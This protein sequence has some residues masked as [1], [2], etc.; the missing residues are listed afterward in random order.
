MSTSSFQG[1]YQSPININKELAEYDSSLKPLEINYDPKSAIKI[2][3]VGHCFNVEFEDT[4][5]KSVLTGG[6]LN[7]VY[8]LLQC[9]FHWGSSDIEG[10]EHS[11]DGIKYPSEMH[12]VHWNVQKYSSAAEAAKHCNGLAVIGVFLEVGKR[13]PGIEN[14][15]DHLD[16]IKTKG[17]EDTF[18]ELDLLS[19]LPKDLQ[20]WTYPGSL[21]VAPFS[22]CVTWIILKET[23]TISTK[24]LEKFRS[25][26]CTS[27]NEDPCPI[28]KNNRCIQPLEGRIVRSS[29]W[30]NRTF[31]TT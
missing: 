14:I 13:N 15:I 4:K 24:Q 7:E 21:T 8:R 2:V 12:L 26:L 16:N 5:G 27:E 11:I 30:Q 17:K 6:P 10:S 23:I 20:Y 18:T 28:L 3:N 31:S 25:V 22:E 1:H 9:H 19:L 29:W